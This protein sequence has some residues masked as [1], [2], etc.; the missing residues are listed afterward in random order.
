MILDKTY[1]HL[2]YGCGACCSYDYAYLMADPTY[3]SVNGTQAVDA[4]GDNTCTG[5]QDNLDSYYRN[6]TWWTGD[7]S[8]ATMTSLLAH[9]V[10]AGS[11]TGFASARIPQP[12][13]RGCIL[14]AVEAAT[15]IQALLVTITI[16]SSGVIPTAN[17]ARTAYANETGTYSL[18]QIT[19]G[20]DCF[21]GYQATGALNPST[22]TGTVT[23]VRTKQ[24]ADYVGATGQTLFDSYPPG[25]PDSSGAAF[26]VTTPTGGVVYDL[27]APFQLPSQNQ[28]W[29]KRMNFFENAQ[30]PDGTYVA[31]ELSFYVR[32][33]CQWGS[34][35]STFAADVPGDNV[36]GM[37]TTKTSWNL[38]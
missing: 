9:G 20:L 21:I 2:A 33:S 1:G 5:N 15:P 28:T 29:R 12:A 24:G 4:F 17:S 26:E 23:L 7:S 14:A 3:V 8:I 31:N 35:G 30:L 34:S 32:F 19:D 6:G 18:G 10:P 25:Y 22:Y 27:D 38:Q 36:L 11:T 13:P 37:G 16:Q